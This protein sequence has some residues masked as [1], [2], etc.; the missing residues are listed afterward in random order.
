MTALSSG[1]SA[2]AANAAV[3]HPATRELGSLLAEPEAADGIKALFYH[4]TPRP[5]SRIRPCSTE[6]EKGKLVG[7]GPRSVP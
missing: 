6:E 3:F 7:N 2:T 1:R 5:K 4:L